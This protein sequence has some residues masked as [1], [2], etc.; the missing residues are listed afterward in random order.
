[1]ICTKKNFE[2]CFRKLNRDRDRERE[3]KYL[4]K[5][6]KLKCVTGFFIGEK[7]HPIF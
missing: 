3:E 2:F 4:S 1:M 7:S 6:V 5:E